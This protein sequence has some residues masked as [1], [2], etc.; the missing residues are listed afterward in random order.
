MSENKRC[1]PAPAEQSARFA[2]CAVEARQGRQLLR[3]LD[4]KRLDAVVDT[5]DR[6]GAAESAVTV[7]ALG[8]ALL[9]ALR[10]MAQQQATIRWLGPGQR[11]STAEGRLCRLARSD[12][13][14]DI[15]LRHFAPDMDETRA[16]ENRRQHDARSCR[17]AN[18]RRHIS[19][20]P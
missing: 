3:L 15:P 9:N 1:L 13:I 16:F 5:G 18:A 20:S 10:V 12:V 2:S 11:P 17:R 4:L 7:V 6:D 19:P 14:R 8:S